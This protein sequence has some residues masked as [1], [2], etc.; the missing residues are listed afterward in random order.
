M[1]RIRSNSLSEFKLESITKLLLQLLSKYFQPSK[2][3]DYH[4]KFFEYLKQT[5]NLLKSLPKM[6][7]NNN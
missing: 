6:K 2:L 3:R 1:A 4:T 7:Q 5:S